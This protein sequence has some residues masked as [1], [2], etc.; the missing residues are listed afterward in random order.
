MLPLLP[1][2]AQ[3][4]WPWLGDPRAAVPASRPR[5]GPLLGPVRPGLSDLH[6]LASCPAPRT[7]HPHSGDTAVCC[8]RP[9]CELCRSVSLASGQV[10][11]ACG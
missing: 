3:G 9:L 8:Q 4:G 5:T 11:R 1:R 6:Q 10:S 2:A 7:S